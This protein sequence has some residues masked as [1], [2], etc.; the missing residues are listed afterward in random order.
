MQRKR[1]PIINK[2]RIGTKMETY[3]DHGRVTSRVIRYEYAE[4]SQQK[5]RNAVSGRVPIQDR[6][7]TALLECRD[8][9][10]VEPTAALY[11]EWRETLDAEERTAAPSLTAVCPIAF[12]SWPAARKA[13]GMMER[14]SPIGAR[15]P[16]PVWSYNDCVALVQRWIKE[17]DGPT[18]FAGF[19]MWVDDH[20]R[21]GEPIP[22]VSTV[23]LRLRLPWSGILNLASQN[24]QTAART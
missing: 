2:Q 15:G 23:R 10:Q 1:S 19:N 13:A 8:A 12:P 22:S 9:L 6:V 11:K 7:V 20:R 16:K 4:H 21:K 5:Q 17:T 18:T 3:H 14:V 24:T